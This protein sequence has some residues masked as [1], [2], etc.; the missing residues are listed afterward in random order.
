MSWKEFIASIVG[1]LAWPVVV[2]VLSLVFRQRFGELLGRVTG[3]EGFG[4][5]VSFGKKLA[6]IEAKVETLKTTTLIPT[7]N[8]PRD[9]LGDLAQSSEENPSFVLLASW[10]RVMGAAADLVGAWTQV[11]VKGPRSSSQTATL[12]WIR[13]HRAVSDG[14]QETLN[15]L[16]QLR[17]AVAH[18]QHRPVP[19]EAVTYVEIASEVADILRSAANNPPRSVV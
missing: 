12:D 14:V 3:W 1:D 11:G 18:G 6:D 7:L 2:V 5:K 16:R 17:N 13:K 19:G 9:E 15:S 10:E 8:T 4:Q